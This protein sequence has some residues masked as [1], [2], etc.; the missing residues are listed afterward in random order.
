MKQIV[1]YVDKGVDGNALRQ[2]VKSLQRELEMGSYSLKRM[3][4]KAL[5]EE[6][7]QK[8][9]ALLV[10]PGG[11]DIYY[12]DALAGKG[13]EKIGEFVSNGGSYLGICAGAYFASGA[14]EFEKGGPLQVC[15][16][17]CLKFYPG[18]AVGPAYGP[19]RYSYQDDRGVEI[20]TLLI[21]DEEYCTYYNGGCLFKSPEKYPSVEVLAHYADIEG[22]PAAII[23]CKVGKGKA[24]LS[25]V[26][27]EFSPQHLS[28]ES[29]YINRI[30]P[31]LERGDEKRRTLFRSVLSTLL[32]TF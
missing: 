22:N 5:Q 13:T 29:P 6:D 10:V 9:T 19:N 26:H 31:L 11:R 18:L 21:K 1:I 7:W 15:A 23:S 25:G 4:A 12:E 20:A 16:D 2:T 14:I 28:R 17:R 24:I 3:D 27:L 8:N 32:M 30:Y